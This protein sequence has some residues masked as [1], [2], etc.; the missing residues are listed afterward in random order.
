[1][2]TYYIDTTTDPDAAAARA[3]R[4]R[5]HA[6][7]DRAGRREPQF[8]FDFVDGVTNP[9]NVESTP[10]GNSPNQIRKANLF[11]SA[12]S[13][14]IEHQTNQYFRNSMATDVGLRSLSFVN[15]YQ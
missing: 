15:R 8:T 10:D 9:S 3:P 1:M 14:D 2:V 6:A 11:L 13:H 4:Q 7:R 12:R 5:R